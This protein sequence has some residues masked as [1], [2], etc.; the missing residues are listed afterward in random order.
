MVEVA[1]TNRSAASQSRDDALFAA[2]ARRFIP[3]LFLSYMIAQVDRMDVGFA[4]LT[5]LAN[6]GFSEAVYGIGAGV[7]F[8]GYVLCEVPS[9]ILLKRYGAPMWLG[10]IMVSWGLVSMALMFTRSP[11]SFY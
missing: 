2:I 11:A 4:K 10:R 5:M 1:A 7:F 6:L 3:F 9:N 8:V